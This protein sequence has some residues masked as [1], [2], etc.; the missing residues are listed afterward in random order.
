MDF[1]LKRIICNPRNKSILV[2]IYEL[3]LITALF[4]AFQFQFYVIFL[5]RLSGARLSCRALQKIKISI[6]S[7]DFFSLFER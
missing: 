6:F 4:N 3:R 7:Y 2:W 5:K 1:F